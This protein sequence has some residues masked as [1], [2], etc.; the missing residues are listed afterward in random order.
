MPWFPDM[1]PESK[2]NEILFD[3]RNLAQKM[4]IGFKTGPMRH[5][6]TRAYTTRWPSYLHKA[7][8][9]IRLPRPDI[10]LGNVGHTAVKREIHAQRC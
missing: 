4:R 2:F 6:Y 9:W 8:F 10:W 7:V 3:M 5:P 1:P